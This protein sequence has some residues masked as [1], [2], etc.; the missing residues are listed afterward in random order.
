MSR[1]RAEYYPMAQYLVECGKDGFIAHN[2][3]IRRPYLVSIGSHV[4]IDWGFYCTTALVTGD[5][6]HIAPYVVVLGGEKGK[7][8]LGH[9]CVIGT[10]SYMISGSDGLVGAGLVGP[11]IPEPYKDDLKIEP[12]TFENFAG[13]A[14]H[15]VIT[16]GVTL[17]EGSFI[18][19]CSLVT[20]DT[21]PWTIYY[22]TPAKPVKA[23]KSK[24][25]KEYARK[26]GYDL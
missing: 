5:Y 26:L 4:N 16:P 8:K 2:V 22:G 12:I 7:L 3:H 9:F 1:T 20:K 13:V 10:G 23:R 17:A 24:T 19:A 25:M 6:C 15:V 21:E 14:T 18:G 11:T